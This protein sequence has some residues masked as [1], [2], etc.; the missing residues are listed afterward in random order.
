HPEEQ[1]DDVPVDAGLRVEERRLGIDDA[2]DDHPRHPAERGGD[3]V[4]PLGRDQRVADDEDREGGA[5]EDHAVLFR[6]PRVEL[7]SRLS[8]Q[9]ASR[10]KRLTD[11]RRSS[12]R[13]TW[14]RAATAST[15]SPGR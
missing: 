10:P 6:K 2:D 11:R 7:G 14:S 13:P 15:W 5:R 9:P 1:E 4:D 3:P 8:Y 12:T